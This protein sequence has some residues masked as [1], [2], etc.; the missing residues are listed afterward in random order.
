MWCNKCCCSQV[1]SSWIFWFLAP[2]FTRRLRSRCAKASANYRHKTIYFMVKIISTC[3]GTYVRFQTLSFRNSSNSCGNP[4]LPSHAHLE[5]SRLTAVGVQRR[6]KDLTRRNSWAV[7]RDTHVG[8]GFPLAS[9]SSWKYSSKGKA[10]CTFDCFV[11]VGT[12]WTKDKKMRLKNT[13]FK[14]W[15]KLV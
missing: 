10:T 3:R 2:V 9:H 1:T 11:M 13:L 5:S 14:N 12:C 15:A 8:S 6:K 4:Q 7:W